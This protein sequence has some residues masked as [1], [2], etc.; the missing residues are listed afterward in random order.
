M[1]EKPP[2]RVN[3]NGCGGT[4]D[5]R[6]VTCPACL[7]RCS[8]DGAD[9]EAAERA[10]RVFQLRVPRFTLAQIDCE[11]G[12][13]AA[14]EPPDPALLRA[15]EKRWARRSYRPEAHSE[16]FGGIEYQCGGCRFF[17]ATGSDYGVCFNERSPLDGCVCFE[18]GGCLGHSERGGG[19]AEEEDDRH[20][21]WCGRETRHALHDSGHERDSSGDYRECKECGKRTFGM[22]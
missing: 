20:C 14:E 6:G 13:W 12:G 16:E 4:G 9:R 15:A 19:G 1:S 3:C 10:F 5:I 8:H 7:G 17:A 22:C 21:E 11:A 2:D 18:H